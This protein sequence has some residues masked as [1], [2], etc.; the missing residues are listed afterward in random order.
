M[1]ATQE[2][3]VAPKA[4]YRRFYFV[5]FATAFVLRIVCMLWWKSYIFPTVVPY[6]EVGRLIEK[7]ATGQGFS[8]P[9]GGNSGPTG[10]FP[11]VYPF[12]GSLIYRM[13]GGY[14]NATNIAIL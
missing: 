3:P 8:S 14:S 5:L 10:A 13:F 12:L 7:L 6:N 1:P 2:G 4:D 9:Y 11:P